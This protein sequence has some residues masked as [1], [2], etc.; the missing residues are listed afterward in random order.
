[1]A[2]KTRWKTESVQIHATLSPDL[3]SR[4]EKVVLGGTDPKAQIT[5][6]TSVQE[7]KQHIR[8]YPKLC[9]PRCNFQIVLCFEIRWN[10]LAPPTQDRPPTLRRSLGPMLFG[11]ASLMS[12]SALERESLYHIRFIKSFCKRQFPHKFVDL[13]FII[14][15]VRNKLTN[16]AGINICK[17]TL[18]TLSVR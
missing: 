13:S 12:S 9:K 5:E 1:M 4:R 2:P 10:P 14:T 11:S 8:P 15:N 6:H 17:T 7:E 3:V 18:R 16:C